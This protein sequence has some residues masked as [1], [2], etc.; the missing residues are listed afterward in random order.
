MTPLVF[1]TGASI[2][3]LT[4][5]ASTR[6]MRKPDP[7]CP[8]RPGGSAMSSSRFREAYLISGRIVSA[9]M[10]IWSA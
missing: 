2:G 6:A 1:I 9:V 4:Q 8:M 7:A 3:T 5:V 10:R